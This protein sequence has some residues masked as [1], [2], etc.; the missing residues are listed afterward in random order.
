VLTANQ[1]AAQAAQDARIPNAQSQSQLKLQIILDELCLKHD[2]ALA[3][4]VY[5]FALNPTLITTIGGIT[6]FGGPYPLPLDYLRTSGSTGSEGVQYAFFYVY[7]GVPYP[8]RPWDLGRLD[9]QVQQPG[10]Q[11]L[12]YAFA[13]DIS[14]ETTA[15]DRIA[16]TTTAKTTLGSAEI[17]VFSLAN[18]KAGQAIAGNGI[19]PGSVIT[20][21]PRDPTAPALSSEWGEMVWGSGEWAAAVPPPT[22]QRITLSLPATATFPNIQGLGSAAIMFGVAPVAYVYPGPSGA[23]P[24]TLRYQRLMPP[25]VDLS[26]V[27]WFTDQNYLLQRLTAEL[28]STSDDTRR[29]GLLQQSR[30]ILGDY[31]AFSDDKTNRAQTVLLDV[32][33]FSRGFHKLRNTKTIGW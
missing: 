24:T 6:N 25:L 29:D 12:P 7:N 14:T 15:A 22:H 17:E 16:G 31:Q 32:N 23:F 3:R 5:Y 11:N 18:I 9:M 13:T 30:Q 2:F 21:A 27:P 33:R 1:L 20:S 4:G 26:R 28:M 8:L 19:A 10:I